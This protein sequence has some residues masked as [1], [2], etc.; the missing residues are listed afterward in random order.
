MADWLEDDDYEGLTINGR[1][2]EVRQL[3]LDRERELRYL[4]RVHKAVNFN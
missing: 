2:A 4:E 3:E 1:D